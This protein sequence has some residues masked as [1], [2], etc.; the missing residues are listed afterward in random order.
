MQLITYQLAILYKPT[1]TIERF[2]RCEQ[3]LRYG[4]YTILLFGSSY[5]LAV[6]GA[7]LS[8]HL[9]YGIPLALR[10]PI[11]RYYA[12]EAFF[13][14]PV[15]IATWVM[16][17]GLVQ[18]LARAFRGGGS[19]EDTL[20]ATGLPFVALIAFMLLPDIVV[21]YLLPESVK[22]AS[23]FARLINPARL[24]AA[25]LWLLVL[26]VIAVRAVQRLSLLKSAVITAIAYVPY[27]GITMTYMR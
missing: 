18:L 24:T 17:A 23:V 2:L 26:H 1:A 15:T 11:D 22:S 3:R 12:Y 16:F 21:D 5:T 8:R 14:L 9:P 20:A 25:S 19:F 6:I 13:L 27:M 4:L 7:Y 10:I